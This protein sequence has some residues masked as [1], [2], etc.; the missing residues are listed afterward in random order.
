MTLKEFKAWFEGYST[1]IFLSEETKNAIKLI[2]AELDL[3][4]PDIRI[5]Y[6]S[7]SNFDG[8]L[9]TDGPVRKY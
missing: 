8:T 6:V 3:V 4:E 5:Q 2:K 1:R 9:R 7:E